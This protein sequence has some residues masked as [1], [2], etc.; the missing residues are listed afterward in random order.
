VN[1]VLSAA[2]FQRKSWQLFWD[3]GKGFNAKDSLPL[4]ALTKSNNEMW[5]ISAIIAGELKALRIDPPPGSAVYITDIKLKT[6][7]AVHDVS[8]T[9]VRLHMMSADRSNLIVSGD[10]DPY[11]VFDVSEYFKNINGNNMVE[12]S[13]K[14]RLADYEKLLGAGN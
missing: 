9:E 4:L 11:F 10:D 5:S 14:V 1:K 12:V 6:E 8:V 7:V 13:F 2:I 3:V